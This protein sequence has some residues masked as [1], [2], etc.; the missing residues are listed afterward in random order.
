MRIDQ[1]APALQEFLAISQ[2]VGALCPQWCQ[3]ESG[4]V[5]IKYARGA[6][7]NVLIKKP[8]VRITEVSSDFGWQEF[9]VD[10]LLEQLDEPL[11][12]EWLDSHHASVH[13]LMPAKVV[14]E[15]TSLVS[16]LMAHEHNH[17]MNVPCWLSERLGAEVAIV[18][19]PKSL[20]DLFSSICGHIN[21]TAI[22]I[23]NYGV[24]LQDE[25]AEIVAKWQEVEKEFCER[26][27][28]LRLLKHLGGA[29]IAEVTEAPA[30]KKNYLGGPRRHKYVPTDALAEAIKSTRNPRKSAEKHFHLHS[31]DPCVNELWQAH[32]ILYAECPN[33]AELPTTAA[34][35]FIHR[36]RTLHDDDLLFRRR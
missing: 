18:P 13:A 24:I 19:Y 36:S 20:D 32:Q 8:S 21:K 5:S 14:V 2:R 1:V 3:A 29:S 23:A 16:L 30:P 22:V 25:T 9:P 27:G 33:L 10:K 15:L 26:L 35:A 17:D 12:S 28:Y 6:G 7:R 4:Y 31:D 11:V 34:A